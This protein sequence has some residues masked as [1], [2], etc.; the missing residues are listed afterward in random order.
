MAEWVGRLLGRLGR[1][2]GEI[3][4]GKKWDFLIYKVSGNCTR[5]FRRNFDVGIFPKFF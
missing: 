2:P 1:K 3:P 4:F 5:I